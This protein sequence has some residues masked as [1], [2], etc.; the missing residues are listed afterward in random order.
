MTVMSLREA[1]ELYGEELLIAATGAIPKEGHGP[2]GDVRVIY[3]GSHGVFLNLG[4][5]IRDQVRLPT[6]PD[7]KAVLA[8][9]AEEGGEHFVL[10]YDVKKAHRRIPVL[11]SEWG[12][13]ACQVRGSAAAA[14]QLRKAKRG[15]PALPLRPQAATPPGCS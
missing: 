11:P 1:I 5:K 2:D 3:D 14:L 7:L 6:A 8:E 13:Q 9:M 4:I 12:R 10:V 15:R